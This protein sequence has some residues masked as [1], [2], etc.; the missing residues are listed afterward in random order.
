MNWYWQ[1]KGSKAQLSRTIQFFAVVLTAM[2]AIIP[3]AIN[4]SGNQPK[5]VDKEEKIT[6]TK[7]WVHINVPPGQ[8]RV[9]ATFA[10]W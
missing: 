8:Y 5:S 2:G 7:K 4:L 1:K 9:P 10:R 3:V 6:G